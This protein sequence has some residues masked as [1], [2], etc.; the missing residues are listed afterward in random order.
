MLRRNWLG[1]AFKFK[2]CIGGQTILLPGIDQA[3]Q[4]QG[5]SRTGRDDQIARQRIGAKT[6]GPIR[7]DGI[8]AV[9]AQTQCASEYLPR[10]QCEKE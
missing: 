8:V 7:A 9:I 1:R 3:N 2:R 5:R 10:D 6:A 4:R